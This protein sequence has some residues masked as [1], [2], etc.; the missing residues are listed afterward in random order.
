MTNNRIDWRENNLKKLQ[1]IIYDQQC[2]DPGVWASKMGCS[3]EEIHSNLVSNVV[4]RQAVEQ[5]IDR[6]IFKLGQAWL[7]STKDKESE[8]NPAQTKAFIAWL[9]KKEYLPEL[10]ETHESDIGLEDIFRVE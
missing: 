5:A 4:F 8:V 2:I 7:E 1:K 10:I 9:R 3:Y 6:L